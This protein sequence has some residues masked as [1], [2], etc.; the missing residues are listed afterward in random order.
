MSQ[1]DE[2][3]AMYLIYQSSKVTCVFSNVVSVGY[4]VLV[5]LPVSSSIFIAKPCSDL[6]L[7][8][9]H[10]QLDLPDLLHYVVRSGSS[11]YIQKE[12]KNGLV[13]C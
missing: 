3:F 10:S 13:E 12:N 8:I 4:F 9:L 11:K 5:F 7:C 1:F 2:V 6:V